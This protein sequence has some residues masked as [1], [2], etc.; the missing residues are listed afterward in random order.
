MFNQSR[1][2]ILKGLAYGS[3]LTAGAISGLAVAKSN[4]Q[5]SGAGADLATDGIHLLPTQHLQAKTLSLFN[6]TDTDVTIGSI[7]QLNRGDGNR[8]LAVKFDTS[9]KQTGVTL[10]PGE[11]REFPV[12][13]ASNGHQRIIASNTTIPI[14]VF[15]SK[16]A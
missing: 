3:A 6:H 1:R 13:A 4:G 16:A 7:N 8:F 9:G 5:I 11:S 10:T 15:D 14:T 12:A 2:T